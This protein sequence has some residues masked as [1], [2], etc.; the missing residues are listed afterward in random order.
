MFYWNADDAGCYDLKMIYF[1][2][3]GYDFG[4]VFFKFFW[5]EAK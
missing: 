1:R 4:G 3:D 2:L 5:I